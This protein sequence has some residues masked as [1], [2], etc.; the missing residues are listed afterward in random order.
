MSKDLALHGKFTSLENRS[1]D[2][3]RDTTA[4][5]LPTINRNMFYRR[6]VKQEFN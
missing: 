3:N 6:N 2:E 4:A 5:K 1:S